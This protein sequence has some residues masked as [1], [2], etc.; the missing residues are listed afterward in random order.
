MTS[1]R[2]SKRNVRSVLLAAGAIAGLVRA[3]HAEGF[4]DSQIGLAQKYLGNTELPAKGLVMM[5]FKL[6]EGHCFYYRGAIETGGKAPDAN[7]IFELASVTKV[8]TTAILAMRANQ[9]SINPADPVK[10]HLPPGYKLDAEKSGSGEDQVTYQ[11]LATF[12][13]GFSWSDPPGFDSNALTIYS[14]HDFETAVNGLKPGKKE[15]PSG[16]GL[17]TYY[18]YSNGSVGFLGQIL[19]YWDGYPDYAEEGGFAD[20]IYVNLTL[21]LG[22]YNTT[23][24]PGQPGTPAY[25]LQSGGAWAT[26]YDQKFE[27]QTPFPWEPW[28]AAGGLRSNANDM[29]I[30]LQ[31]NIC[32][33]HK[34]DPNCSGFP[35]DIL[36]AL[37]LAHT[38]NSYTSPGSPI[39]S[40]L[41]KGV[42]QPGEAAWAW[43]YRPPQNSAQTLVIE[44]NGGHQGCSSFIGFDPDKGYGLVVLMN[45]HQDTLGDQCRQIIWD[46]LIP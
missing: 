5:S 16:A 22:M 39:I 20:W 7:T 11:Q 36:D 28:G 29:L 17:P 23:V 14:Q 15:E 42:T 18:N 31:A 40:L 41:D 2:V 27:P 43:D 44:K 35:G 6:G 4:C 3:G 21:P 19:M 24:E 33:H 13:G 30:F 37:A 25:Q 9:N 38:P 34:S 12:T 8:F 10:P 1:G 45:T 26:G 46:T 32:A